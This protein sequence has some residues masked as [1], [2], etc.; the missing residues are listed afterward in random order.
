MTLYGE[1]RTWLNTFPQGEPVD[2]QCEHLAIRYSGEIIRASSW[3]QG[4]GEELT[5]DTMFHIVLLGQ[6]RGSQVPALNDDLLAFIRRV[7]V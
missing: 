5:S 4:W 7:L 1:P 3:N 6:R 2:F